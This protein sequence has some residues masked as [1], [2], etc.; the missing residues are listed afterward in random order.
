MSSEPEA[1][2]QSQ[3]VPLAIPRLRVGA[4][5]KLQPRVTTFRGGQ[6]HTSIKRSAAVGSSGSGS[7]QIQPRAKA[8]AKGRGG[9]SKKV[10]LGHGFSQMDWIRLN[11]RAKDMNGLAGGPHRSVTMKELQQHSS[12]FDCWMALRGKVYNVSKYFPY[13]P[14]GV[15]ELKRGAGK[16]GTA[17]FDEF[18]RWVSI[19]GFLQKC[20]IGPL[21][22]DAADA[23]AT[24]VAESSTPSKVSS[25]MSPSEWRSFNLV[26][27]RQLSSMTWLLR[28]AFQEKGASFGWEAE[29]HIRVRVSING[30]VTEREY[31]PVSPLSQTG[32]FDLAVKVYPKGKLSLFLFNMKVGDAIEMSGGHGDI[33]IRKDAS[34][35]GFVVDQLHGATVQWQH[36]LLLAGGSGITPMLQI[37]RAW[38][39][40]GGKGRATLVFA[41]T[42]IDEVPM[43][44]VLDALGR[45]ESINLD[46]RYLISNPPLE[47]RAA[48]V[49]W[50][51]SGRIS[52][53][54]LRG[55]LENRIPNVALI[56]GPPGFNDAAREISVNLGVD[57]TNIMQF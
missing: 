35:G 42:E 12:Q 36:V 39:D 45:D 10:R 4:A 8:R 51:D 38:R 23:D 6:E 32:T 16:D 28:F 2:Q 34:V 53:S 48:G 7:A 21:I 11:N 52:I 14:G 47:Q 15:E 13:H 37:L 54:Y 46:V 25:P 9:R 40:G 44:D 49:Q 27:R 24:S 41:N 18:H 33:S 43:K 5:R 26:G 57:S 30:V 50:W 56:C 20:Y 31:T 29:R 17:L 22:V 55:V 19:D 1:P 3:R